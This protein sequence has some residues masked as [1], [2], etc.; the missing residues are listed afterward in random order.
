MGIA[1]Q[2]YFEDVIMYLSVLRYI[3]KSRSKKG[4]F[5]LNKKAETFFR[6]VLNIVY[7]WRLKDLNKIQSNYPAI[8]LADDEELVCVQVTAESGS[9]KINKTL[10]KFF[11]KKFDSKYVRI[12]FMIITEKKAYSKDFS[13]P[14]SFV[15]NKS[16]DIKDIDD[17]LDDVEALSLDRLKALHEYLKQELAGI[18]ASVAEPGTLLAT[19]ERPAN[20]PAKNGLALFNH[21][22]YQNDEQKKGM[23]DLSRFYTTLISLP[24]EI[25][26]YLFTIV[27][28]GYESQSFGNTRI[29]IIPTE[30]ES[31][32]KITRSKSVELF[33]VLDQKGIGAVDDSDAIHYLEVFFFM[34]T[35][36]ELLK[37]LKDFSK[38]EGILIDLL[39]NCNFEL[40]DTAL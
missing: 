35:G 5:D 13:V 12:M 16:S 34:D 19:A 39:V 20:T 31:R 36:V 26:E 32:L 17:L 25:R 6:D 14:S 23:E 8:D 21:L 3:F 2:K 18:V 30:L 22:Q 7:D 38:S 33:Q 4:Y 28:N 11:D 29:I 24:K 37:E 15:F 27:W 9:A 1:S 40:L 10:V